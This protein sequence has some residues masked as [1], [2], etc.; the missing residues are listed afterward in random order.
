[1]FLHS[2]SPRRVSALPRAIVRLITFYFAGQIIQ[3]SLLIL[4]NANHKISF[5]NSMV[6]VAKKK[7]NN[8]KMARGRAETCRWEK[9]CKNILVINTLNK[10]CLTIFYLYFVILYITTGVSHLKG[11]KVRY[12]VYKSL[13]L[14]LILCHMNPVYALPSF[15]P[16]FCDTF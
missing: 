15:L 11:P 4:C 6:C 14:F 1:M 3:L 16:Y 8:L 9:L 12:H 2:F 10:L 5:A 13:P 7:V